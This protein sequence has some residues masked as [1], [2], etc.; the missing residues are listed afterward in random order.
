MLLHFRYLKCKE[1][2]EDQLLCEGERN[3]QKRRIT[4]Q[5]IRLDGEPAI[6]LFK[7]RQNNIACEYKLLSDK[8]VLDCYS[9]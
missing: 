5:D 6:N 8:D 3:V 1:G 2:H 4:V 7:D 9:L